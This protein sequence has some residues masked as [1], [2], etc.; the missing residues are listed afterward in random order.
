MIT[1]LYRLNGGEILGSS[2]DVG[3]YDGVDTR[4]VATVV[5]DEKELVDGSNLADAKIYDGTTIRNATK[6]E[7]VVLGDARTL[8]ET[9][10]Q[11][12]AAITLVMT[13][14]I[15]RK[16]FGASV[17]TLSKAQGAETRADLLQPIIDAINSGNYD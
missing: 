3:T 8:D 15:W 7:L 1:F 4:Y 17:A 2:T 16:V 5:V 13:H 9:L 10:Q 14:P 6:E 12:D 11:R